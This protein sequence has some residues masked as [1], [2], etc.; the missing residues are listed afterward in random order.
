MDTGEFVDRSN[1]RSSRAIHGSRR[2]RMV[3]GKIVGDRYRRGRCAEGSVPLTL[4][5]VSRSSHDSCFNVIRAGRATKRFG[6]ILKQARGI[7]RDIL[8]NVGS[9]NGR[10]VPL[11][12]RHHGQGS[13]Q[14]SILGVIMSSGDWRRHGSRW[15]TH[16]ALV[17]RGRLH[18]CMLIVLAFA[19]RTGRESSDRTAVRESWLEPEFFIDVGGEGLA[20]GLNL[21]LEVLHRPCGDALL[22]NTHVTRKVFLSVDIEVG[23]RVCDGGQVNHGAGEDAVNGKIDASLHV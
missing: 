4:A 7:P 13:S 20:Q 22:K 19:Q 2:V 14:R 17:L 1:G 16:V 23:V 8:A 9:G 11:S 21:L 5:G 3:L 6:A 10:R 15:I 18:N 12:G